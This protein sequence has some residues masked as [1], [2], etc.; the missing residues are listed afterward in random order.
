MRYVTFERSLKSLWMMCTQHEASKS[1]YQLKLYLLLHFIYTSQIFTQREI[2]NIPRGLFFPLLGYLFVPSLCCQL[3]NSCFM[4]GCLA[5]QSIRHKTLPL[6]FQHDSMTGQWAAGLIKNYRRR[7]RSPPRFSTNGDRVL[8][9]ETNPP[10]TVGGHDVQMLSLKSGQPQCLWHYRFVQPK[11]HFSEAWRGPELKKD[12]RGMKGNSF[13]ICAIDELIAPP[14]L[15]RASFQSL[16]VP[17]AWKSIAHTMIFCLTP[18]LVYKTDYPIII[19]RYRWLIV[20]TKLDKHFFCPLR[21]I[22]IN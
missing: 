15:I 19:E 16:S 9:V 12:N 6:G 4:S 8:R 22:I 10:E 3:W 1:R 17:A 7:K 2:W 14:G 21:V 5:T 20:G 11:S 18:F 13:S